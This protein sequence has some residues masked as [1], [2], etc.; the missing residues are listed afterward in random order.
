MKPYLVVEGRTDAEILRRF[1]PR[2]LQQHY[3]LVIGDG[4]SSAISDARTL[5]TLSREPVALVVDA[6]TTDPDQVREE[7]STTRQLLQSASAGI[8]CEVFLAVPNL[9]GI[10]QNHGAV[11]QIPLIRNLVR[12]IRENSRVS[13]PTAA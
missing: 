12:F 8:N 4:K 13:L 7:E 10:R 2:S 9:E 11:N 6:D 5:L 3:K 1:L